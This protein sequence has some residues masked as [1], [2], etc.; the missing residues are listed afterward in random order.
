[1]KHRHVFACDNDEH[2]AKTIRAIFPTDK[3]YTDANERDNDRVPQVDVYVAGFP[4][5]PFSTA[6]KQ[7]GFEDMKDGVR[8]IIF[9]KILKYI[10]E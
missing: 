10:Q 3:F 8:G 5:Q 9:V 6:G 7:Q 1:M 4:C 2:V